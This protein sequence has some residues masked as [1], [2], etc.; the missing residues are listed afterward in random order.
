MTNNTPNPPPGYDSWLAFYD[1]TVAQMPHCNQFVDRNNTYWSD[2]QIIRYA[3]EELDAARPTQR[4]CLLVHNALSI[5]GSLNSEEKEIIRKLQTAA[6]L[7][8]V[9]RLREQ[10]AFTLSKENNA[11][12]VEFTTED[13]KRAVWDNN[14]NRVE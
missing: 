1:D 13:G 3:F 11:P 8:E 4:E 10:N 7:T 6:R 2:F 12:Y 9:E 14:G 5:T